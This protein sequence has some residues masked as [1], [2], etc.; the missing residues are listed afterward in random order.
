[1]ADARDAVVTERGGTD[2]LGRAQRGAELGQGRAPGILAGIA[3]DELG[4]VVPVH[5]EV[6]KRHRPVDTEVHR[7]H[8]AVAGVLPSQTDAGARHQ[9]GD[10]VGGIFE[11]RRG[12]HGGRV[13]I[14]GVGHRI[15][16]VGQ[17]VQQVGPVEAFVELVHRFRRLE[18]GVDHGRRT[19]GT[20]SPTGEEHQLLGVE[21][22]V[23]LAV[24]PDPVVDDVLVVGGRERPAPGP[25]YR[26]PGS[27]PGRKAGKA[28]WVLASYAQ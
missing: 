20:F 7:R 22:V 23:E 4:F 8:G 9:G 5:D 27:T 10:V 15:R 21:V 24:Q 1:M 14:G 19:P 13:E 17:R 11:L 26:Y 18:Q 25:L 16:G 12:Q 28:A 6:V 3:G 2:R